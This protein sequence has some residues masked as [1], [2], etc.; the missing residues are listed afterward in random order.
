MKKIIFATA[1]LLMF[2]A[3]NAMDFSLGIEGAAG[4]NTMKVE[5]GSVESDFDFIPG[6]R[7][8]STAELSFSEVTALEAK[9]LFHNGNGYSCVT[10]AGKA[11]TS[12]WTVDVPL[13][14]KL[15]FAGIDSIP[16][17]FS[18]FAGPSFNFLVGSVEESVAGVR[19]DNSS[20]SLNPFV[21]GLEAGCE[22]AFT[23][24]D[25]FRIGLSVNCD[26]TDFSKTSNVRANR[27]SVMPYLGY[28]F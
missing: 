26:L 12:F 7:F 25:G 14:V 13:V 6:F 23:H 27:I 21:L 20:L 8:G 2:S 5:S 24:S 19:K 22:Y 15:T 1:I 17:R 4:L 10:A 28:R 9:V 3:L 16:G 11:K 18:L